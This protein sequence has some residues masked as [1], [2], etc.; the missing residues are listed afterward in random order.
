MNLSP[1]LQHRLTEYVEARQ[2]RLIEIVTQLIR[3]PSE[4]IPPGGSE[5]DCQVWIAQQLSDLYFFDQVPGLETHP[6]CYP[7]RDYR[8]RP[9][10]GARRKG[11]GGGRSLLLS[12]HIDTVP[13]G[14][15]NWTRDPFGAA[16]EG[17]RIFGRGSNDM[18]AG[19][20][21]NLFVMECLSELDFERP[22]DV[23]FESVVDE[24]FGGCNGTLAGRLR[25][26]NAD[27]A[28]LSEPS[29]LRICPAQRGGRTVHVTFRANNRGVLQGGRFPTGISEQL[30]CFLTGLERFSS[31][32]ARTKVHDMYGSH[33]DPVPVSVTKIVTS[34]WGFGEP[35]TVPDTAQLELYWQLMPG[36][37]QADVES[38][39]FDWLRGVVEFSRI[40]PKLA[41][42]SDGCPA[43]RF[44][45]LSRWCELLLN[46]RKQ[47]RATGLRSPALKGL[48]TCSSFTRVLTSRQ[49]FGEPLEVIPTLPTS[50]WKSN[51]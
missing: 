23:L 27:A 22:G 49:S 2:D 13:R 5:H 7:G 42:P 37:T 43:R 8:K 24:E 20:A 9:N 29:S 18:K 6:L 14:S 38:E 19:V 48:A 46:V 32:R 25:G 31:Q 44:R 50:M 28:I 12:G 47:S 45:L 26:Y 41:S 15:Q 16:I 34:P 21:T 1:G 35:V 11:S 39:F 36:E 51:L 3:M 4:N 33:A 17:N 30:A 40:L 10:L